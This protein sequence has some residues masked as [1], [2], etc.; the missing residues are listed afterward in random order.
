MAAYTGPGNFPYWMSIQNDGVHGNIGAQSENIP[1]I[2]LAVYTYTVT[3]AYQATWAS[4]MGIDL[5]YFTSGNVLISSFTANQGS[6]TGG[7]LYQI[8]AV[9]QAPVNAS[10]AIATVTQTGLPGSTNALQVYQSEVQDS[11]NNQAN[12]NWAFTWTFWPWTPTGTGAVLNWNFSPL[13]AGDSDSLVLDGIIELMGGAQGVPSDVPELLDSNGQ[14]PTFRILAPPS[15]N[16]AGFGYESSY[17]LNAPQPTQDVVASMLLD[18]ERPFGARA[19]NRTMSL[20]IIIFGTM[21]G[22]MNQVLAAR[23]YLMSVIDQQ[24]WQMK[25]TSADTGLPMIFD[26]FRAL[27]ST[28]LYGFNYSSGGSA[29]GQTIGRPNYPLALITLSIQALPYGRSDIDG[30]QSLSFSNPLV[31]GVPV[32]SAQTVDNYS[33]VGNIR[34]I[35][36]AGATSGNSLVI[37][38]SASV[39]AGDGV[40]VAF[41]APNNTAQAVSASDSQGNHYSVAVSSGNG[42]APATSLYILSSPNI[43]KPLTGNSAGTADSITVS[44][45]V[46]ETL[47]ALALAVQ[48]MT[49]VDTTNSTTGSSTAPSIASTA[50]SSSSNFSLAFFSN[51]N[52]QTSSTGGAGWTGTA[53]NSQGSTRIDA[54]WITNTGQAA[55]TSTGSYLS[56]SP[57]CSASV[58][59]DVV[60]GEVWVQDAAHNLLSNNSAHFLP[61]RPMKT[62]WPAAIY[63]KQLSAPVSIVGLPVLSVFFGQSYDSQ[64]PKDPKFVSNVRLAWTLTDTQGRTISFSHTYRRLPWG[65]NP[66]A[67][68]W[69]RINTWIPQGRNRFSY[70]A[71]AAYSVKI[72]NWHGSGHTGYVRMHAWLNGLTANPQTIQNAMSPRGSLY[73]L[74]AL[75]GSARSPISVQCQLPAALPVTRELTTPVAPAVGTF[76]VAPGVFSMNAECV[77][78]GGAGAACNLNR[79]IAGAGGGGGEWAQEP[80]LAVMPNM[81]I[82]YVI[83]AGGSPGQLVNTVVQFTNPGLG[84]WTCPQN[85][86]SVLA[87]VWGAGA[88]GAAGGGGGGGGGYAAIQQ[89]V[90]PGTTYYLWVGKGGKAD[91]GKTTADTDA[92]GGGGSWFGPNGN[93]VGSTGYAYALGGQTGVTGATSGGYGGAASVGT[94]K[95]AGGRGGAS[96]GP[97]GGGG[98]GAGGAGGVGGNGGD[99]SPFAATIGRWQQGG[100][101]GTGNG[102]GGNGGGGAGLPG[103]P[104]AGV[105]P[106]G[107]GGGGFGS[108][109]LNN[110]LNPSVT[111]PGNQQTNFLGGDGAN[112]LVQLSYAVGN[113]S[114]VNG[115]NSRFGSSGTTGTIV[116]ANGGTSAANNSATGGAGGTGSTNTNHNNGGAGALFTTGTQHSYLTTPRTFSAFTS[117]NTLTFNSTQGTSS[118]ALASVAQGVAVALI[119]S[120]AAVSDLS[121]TDSAGNIYELAQEQA[122]GVSANGVTAYAYVANIEFPIQSSSTTLTVSSATSQQYGVIWYAS[123][124][125]ASGVSPVNVNSGHGNGT[126]LT[127][128]FAVQDNTSFL[129]ELAVFVNDANEAMTISNPSFVWAGAGSTSTLTAGSMQMAA[130]A[131]INEG[132]GTGSA[133]GDTATATVST[134]AN[135]ASLAIPLM[136]ANQQQAVIPLCALSRTSAAAS[137]SWAAGLSIQAQG[138]IAVVGAAGTGTGVTAGPSAVTDGG[139]NRYTINKT[140]VLPGNGGIAFLATAPVT[141]SLTQG[142][143]GSVVWGAAA[144]GAPAAY[145]SFYWLPNCTALDASG[146]SAVTGT[147]TGASGTYT[148]NSPN[149]LLFAFQTDAS[150]LSTNGTPASPW[151]ALGNNAA[152]NLNASFYAGQASDEAATVYSNTYSA[153]A[154]WALML[155]GF[156]ANLTGGG[157]GAAGGPNGPGY[158]GIWQFGGAGFAGSGK[159]G[160]G[161]GSVNAVG[162]GAA[163]PGGGGGGAYSNNTSPDAGGQGGQ[164]AVRLTWT[165]PLTTFNTVLIHSLPSDADP[166]VSPIVP[167][168]ITDVP[169]NTE[170]TVPS[171]TGLINSTFNATY[172]VL[173]CAHAWDNPNAGV[174]RQIT[175]TIHQ[176]E[177]PGGPRYSVQVS[178]AV[179]PAIDSVNGVVNMGEVTLPIKDYLGFNDQSYFTLSIN[180]TD[181]NDRFM[182]VLFLDTQG[183]TVLINIDPGQAGYGQYVN[184]FIDEASTSRDLGFIGASMQDREH[185]VSVLDYASINGGALFV[186][187][188]DNLFLTWSPSGAP[189][190]NVTYAPRW[191]LDRM[192]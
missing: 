50:P 47:N 77:G 187:A 100:T 192:V 173:L 154:N 93:K 188:G 44:T 7:S 122:G 159:G 4:G 119:M 178:R 56:S 66:T 152:S 113:G 9:G 23:E 87:E 25:W 28:P 90:T 76:I 130:F 150:N 116:T 185:Q 84:H 8:S 26:C 111:I 139:G 184:Y 127:T 155:A 126:S 35:G 99:S 41:S 80:A 141:A 69:T 186:G 22:G 42:S 82:P 118:A 125:L 167:I 59:A 124:W 21:A 31:N 160:Q 109:G 101:A 57:W 17:D 136:S 27:P 45:T 6:M 46:T 114:P 2:P 117:L 181:T 91:T 97:S 115:G 74:F 65:S 168:P 153:T 166:N 30:V 34:Q 92:R 144:S 81:R 36:A 132:G 112:G 29:T 20:P 183:Q 156:Q 151:N 110:A 121:V 55:K 138:L 191:Y 131:A 172:T 63:A 135:W 37:P 88:A 94:T 60:A 140:T 143:T 145:A 71:V 128:Q 68:R 54:Y 51:N 89:A 170:Y 11:N 72:T 38:L 158:P 165:P 105:I 78:G 171:V 106:G 190:L 13:L 163:L 12:I 40:V 3:A 14:G 15:M 86:T 32:S 176:Y 107:G 5:Q 120:T 70:N 147:T 177:Y 104:G 137:N 148:P 43:S 95:H 189:N 85:I 18:G 96:P 73:N 49:G 61:P 33:V 1:V 103:F 108:L 102:Q 169:N 157:G 48:G 16:S 75:P 83:G 98:G 79:A 53:G 62:P 162:G 142:V 134:P 123:P 174:P 52:T 24:T 175:V 149:D 161:A 164:G 64:W 179:T 133:N 67:P 19:S 146:A 129:F 39:P 10:Y 182:D 180:D 58:V